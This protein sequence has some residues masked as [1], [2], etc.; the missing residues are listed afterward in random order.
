MIKSD[1]EDNSIK[2]KGCP[3]CGAAPTYEPAKDGH[4][5]PHRWPDQVLLAG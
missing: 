5:P 4:E 3:F 2:V 1:G